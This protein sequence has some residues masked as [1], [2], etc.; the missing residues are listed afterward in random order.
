M[1]HFLFLTT[2]F[3]FLLFL[4]S[5]SLAFSVSLPNTEIN[6]KPNV[7]SI[8]T[9]YSDYDDP[10]NP[11]YSKTG[12]P[13]SFSGFDYGGAGS[14]GTNTYGFLSI[15]T[16][17]WDS[18]NDGVWENFWSQT[19]D[20]WI[21]GHFWGLSDNQL[22]Y[23]EDDNIFRFNEIGGHINLYK[24]TTGLDLTAAPNPVP[25]YDGLLDSELPDWN[26]WNGYGDMGDLWLSAD[27]TPG[28]LIGDS[29]TTYTEI[30]TGLTLP[31]SGT[32]N[33]YLD[34]TGG[35]V[36][37]RLDTDGFITGIGTKAD[38]D[39]SVDL[40]G[41]QTQSGW[42]I[43]EDPVLANVVPEPTTLILFGLGLLGFAGIARKKL[44]K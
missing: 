36:G 32:T 37:E 15:A 8:G 23:N 9:D 40:T 11:A 25:D 17:Q 38:L 39:M 13:T 2:A 21:I 12:D 10:D 26:I 3:L 19:E 34:V 29:T 43:G 18:N 28:T 5:E 20:E 30:L 44:K 33:A 24:S 27:F 35:S 22:I 14:G 4:C 1:K 31:P 6:I 41:N 42:N 7:Y 16:L